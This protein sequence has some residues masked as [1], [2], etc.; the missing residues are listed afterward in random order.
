MRDYARFDKYLDRLLQDVYAQPPDEG[1]T[2][3]ATQAVTTLGSIVQNC[4]TVLDIGC[5]QGFMKPIFEKMGYEWTGVTVGEDFAMCQSLKI[6]NVHNADMT[7]LPF[8][9]NSFD[10]VFSRH[11]LE[12]SPFPAITLMEWRRVCKGWLILIAPTPNFW[13]IRG[14]NHYS[15]LPKENLIWLLERSGW[16]VLHENEFTS[17]DPLFLRYWEVYQNTLDEDG[18]ETPSTETAFEQIPNQVV[19]YRLLLEQMEPVLE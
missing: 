2:A 4:N 18:K 6:E 8:E 13:T 3:W 17:R 12:H 14:K 16:G 9:D 7:F 10:L 11:V 15:V 19:E 5:G 1:H